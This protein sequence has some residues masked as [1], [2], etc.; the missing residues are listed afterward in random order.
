[1]RRLV[2]LAALFMAA[3]P[4]N[5]ER[6]YV[7]G[8]SLSDNGNLY[9]ALDGT[10]PPDD[11]YFY[12]RASN[13]P[14]WTERLGYWLKN[15]P[16]LEEV[17]LPFGATEGLDE[18][19]NFAHFGATTIGSL[20][21]AGG[22]RI[23]QQVTYFRQR[24]REC[25]CTITPD[26]LVT[27]WGGAND[28]LA[29]GE[30]STR[31][32]TN[33]L[34]SFSRRLS[35]GGAS[36]ILVL[37]QPYWGNTPIGFDRGDRADLN[38]RMQE[39]NA[40]L[41]SIIDRVRWREG[42]DAY[43]V[44]VSRLFTDVYKNPGEYGFDIVAPGA[45]TT[46]HCLGDGLLLDACTSNYAFYDS[47]HPSAAMHDYIAQ[48]VGAFARGIQSS[49]SA[50]PVASAA[51]APVMAIQAAVVSGDP[52]LV[53]R[54]GFASDT[55]GG[56]TTFAFTDDGGLP[57]TG[58]LLPF[59][60][61][62]GSSSFRLAGGHAQISPDATLSFALSTGVIGAEDAI[63]GPARNASGWAMAY[64][65]S[66]GAFDLSVQSQATS[67]SFVRQRATGF[68]R[69][70]LVTAEF[71]QTQSL[72]M[73]GMSRSFA[74]GGWQVSPSLA[75]GQAQRTRGDIIEYSARN[76]LALNQPGLEEAGGAQMAS[77]AVTRSGALEGA[78]WSFG[79]TA[80]TA[81]VDNGLV[82]AWSALG[83]ID[84][85]DDRTFAVEEAHRLGL[86]GGLRFDTGVELGFTAEIG[87]G[88]G[89]TE[90]AGRMRV[91]FAF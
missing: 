84:L 29:F 73:V 46:G 5:A 7:F 66:L 62:L 77:L 58:F 33:R 39:H 31:R 85:A 18:G 43:Y 32:V 37:D 22:Q 71:E 16:D 82:S 79:V 69:D 42:V 65:Q 87:E 61:E 27:V 45:D 35:R 26:D 50:A 90:A 15:A 54:T 80:A 63:A 67:Q 10:F 89:E 52:T 53:G 13:G 74:F 36:N 30:T 83:A 70:P 20:Q 17:R 60:Q 64:R 19:V 23:G 76:L 3:A 57:G 4:A 88:D 44:P 56:V 9:L 12:G 1:M 38:L 28:Y 24:V 6:L 59:D 48:Y 75:L 68:A 21:P 14:V 25:L 78:D 91:S 81:N 51:S 47:I 55:F 49:K 86:Q 40:R 8:D 2:A 72:T 34:R 11:E 41:N